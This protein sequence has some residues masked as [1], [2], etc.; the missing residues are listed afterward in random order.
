MVDRAAVLE[1]LKSTHEEI[2]PLPNL[3]QIQT[4][5]YQWFLDYGMSEL[6]EHFSPIEDYTGNLALE[7][8]DY[9]LGD[10]KRTEEECR[11]ADVTYEGDQGVGDLPG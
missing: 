5:S 3:T 1:R 8:L 9:R 6:F 4:D 7:F 11:E 2:L 10:P